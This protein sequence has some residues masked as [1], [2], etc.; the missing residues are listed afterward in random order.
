MVN[1]EKKIRASS[2]KNIQFLG[3]GCNGLVMKCEFPFEFQVALKMIINMEEIGAIEHV[4]RTKNEFDILSESA[5]Q[6]HPNIICMLGQFDCKPTKEM[7]EHID[8]TIKD[9]SVF[10]LAGHFRKFS[11]HLFF[12]FL[13]FDY[14]NTK[15]HEY[16]LIPLV[17]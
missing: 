1:D 4:N 17:F 11:G 5:L 7:L 16:F 8:D 6:L 15:F 2:F 13:F 12:H 10:S 9:L 3:K 14:Q